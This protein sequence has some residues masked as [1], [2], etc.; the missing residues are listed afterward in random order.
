[1]DH[2]FVVWLTLELNGCCSNGLSHCQRAIWF[3]TRSI[4]NAK[5]SPRVCW[6]WFVHVYLLLSVTV[7]PSMSVSLSMSVL[8][9]ACVYLLFSVCVAVYLSVSLCLSF[10]LSTV[11]SALCTRKDIVTDRISRFVTYKFQNALPT[12]HER[13]SRNVSLKGIYSQYTSRIKPISCWGYPNTC[14]AVQI[15][16]HTILRRRFIDCIQL[17]RIKQSNNQSE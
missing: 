8:I 1:M 6:H 10:F 17:N 7:S 11:I 16:Q 13:N 5:C 12:L 2:S 15:Q 4:K 3:A 9:C 14:Y